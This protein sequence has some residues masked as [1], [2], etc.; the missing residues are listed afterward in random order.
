MSISEAAKEIVQEVELELHDVAYTVSVYAHREELLVVK[1]EDKDTLDT[2]HGEFAA[3]YI[4][5]ITSKTGS[6]KKFGVFV[7]ML[8]SAVL[9][10]SDSVFVDLLTCQDLEL[11]KAKKGSSSSEQ[12]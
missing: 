7:R 4:E 2:W 11:L 10:Q 6:F 1:I 3:K 8:Q 5:D 12:Y 9:Q